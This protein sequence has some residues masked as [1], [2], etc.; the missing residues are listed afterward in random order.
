MGTIEK[1]YS[2]A[3]KALRSNYKEHGIF[4]GTHHFDD[5]WAR[6]S[7]YASWG[8]LELGDHDIVKKN[9]ELFMG[10]Q[11]KDGQIPVRVGASLLEI[12]LKLF[13]FGPIVKNIPRYHQDKGRNPSTDQCS[14]LIITF[15]R[16]IEKTGDM[17]F[18]KKHIKRIEKA[19]EW[20]QSQDTD[21]DLLIEESPYATWQDN[22]R[23][24]GK[25]LYTNVLH[26]H[27]LACLSNL[28]R[29]LGEIKSSDKY[30]KKNFAVRELINE[31][32][33]IG[34]HYCD[35]IDNKKHTYFSTD[36]NLFAV[37]FGIADRKKAKIIQETLE[38]RGINRFV[39]SLTNLP[40]YPL[41]YSTSI[42]LFFLGVP[43]YQNGICWSWLGCLDVI[44]KHESG[45]QKEAKELIERIAGIFIKY[46]K[47]Y[48][49]YEQSGKP[50]K[51]ILYRSEY[52]FSWTAGLFIAA[53]KRL[54]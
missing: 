17:D 46:E 4:A 15:F 44:A 26:C 52:D 14:L 31:Q 36:G 12:G 53:Y 27:A 54:R 16:Y 45:L 7:L 39:P 48:E 6:D 49:T 8:A 25:V 38:D 19:M 40:R 47:I 13:G 35:W 11:K 10:F 33:W 9:L 22:I 34:T 3:K 21:K 1:A 24:K 30:L 51:R 43:D 42:G 2:I 5:Y 20:N 29:L 23:K 18:L 50:V 41:K 28:Y 37:I 32:F